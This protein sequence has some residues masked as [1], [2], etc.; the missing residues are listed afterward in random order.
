MGGVASAT[1]GGVGRKR[2]KRG[3]RSKAN[4]KSRKR[5]AKVGVVGAVTTGPVAVARCAA[6][7]AAA[8]AARAREALAEQ[9]L[10]DTFAAMAVRSAEASG[11][12][13]EH[14]RWLA[15]MGEHEQKVWFH[16]TGM[17]SRAAVREQ[18]RLLKTRNT[19]GDPRR[20]GTVMEREVGKAQAVAEKSGL[21]GERAGG[22]SGRWDALV[23]DGEASGE[24]ADRLA[25]GEM[26]P[27]PFAVA[28][29]VGVREDFSLSAIR[30]ALARVQEGHALSMQQGPDGQAKQ[31]LRDER[32]DAGRVPVP[33][34]EFVE[35]L[36]PDGCTDERPGFLQR[37]ADGQLECGERFWH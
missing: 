32:T 20:A 2:N 15:N 25:R 10:L 35:A 17:P 23:Q 33:A 24:W 1:T 19:P 31:Q 4:S 5:V 34:V 11:E 14:V 16:S 29:A 3:R 21:L 13:R 7:A 12:A 8:A 28:G 18:L 22:P 36:R 6:S 27:P 9:E 26:P 37:L 30:E